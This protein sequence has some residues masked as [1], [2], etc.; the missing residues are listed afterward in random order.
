MDIVHENIKK[1]APKYSPLVSPCSL[2]RQLPF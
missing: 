1:G 2:I